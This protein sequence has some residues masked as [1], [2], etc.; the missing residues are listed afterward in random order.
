[1]NFLIIIY[2]SLKKLITQKSNSQDIINLDDNL[3]LDNNLNKSIINYDNEKS[4]SKILKLEKKLKKQKIELQ[5]KEEFYKDPWKVI[6][7]WNGKN[8]NGS[9]IF[10]TY[11]KRPPINK[12]YTP[13]FNKRYNNYG[14][15]QRNF[16]NFGV[17]YPQK[18][19]IR[20]NF[21]GG[22]RGA[23]GVP[24]GIRGTRAVL[25]GSGM[26]NNNDKNY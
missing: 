13:Y 21:R 6:N 23:R 2:L 26:I 14:N 4:N 5:K 15:G 11:K 20:G 1:M 22:M 8:I 3:V 9:N 25:R 16:N 18:P 17:N 24:R 19:R 10:V 7:N 12:R